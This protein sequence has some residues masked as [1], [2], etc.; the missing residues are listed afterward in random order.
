M[1]AQKAARVQERR[2]AANRTMKSGSRTA[3]KKA[4]RLI[5]SGSEQAA[6]AVEKAVSMLDRAVTKGVVH[7][8]NAARRKS[9][10][11]QSLR[12]SAPQQ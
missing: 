8:N 1:T 9:R 3:V 7:R 4:R 5:Q 6:G 2:R 12:G 10:L 11:I